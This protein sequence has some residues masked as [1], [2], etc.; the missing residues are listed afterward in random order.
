MNVFY[1]NVC[2]PIGGVGFLNV[3]CFLCFFLKMF[4]C[5]LFMDLE[6]DNKDD[7]DDD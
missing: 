3:L 1:E 6:S 4:L 2:R 7:D 5:V